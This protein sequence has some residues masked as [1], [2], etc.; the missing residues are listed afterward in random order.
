MFKRILSVALA[1]LMVMAMAAVAVSAAEVSNPAG[2]DTTD[3]ATGTS[4]KIYFDASKWNNVT[5]IYCHIWINGGDQFYGWKSAEEKCKN[6][7]GSLWEYDLSALD[8]SSYI[9][10][11]LKAGEDYCLIFHAD[12]G[13][14]GYDTTFGLECIGDRATMTGNQIENPIDSEKKGYETVWS[15]NSSKYGPHFAISSIGNFLG[16]VLCPNESSTKVIG[17][18]LINYSDSQYCDPVEVLAK[19]LPKFGVK[20]VTTVMAYIMTQDLGISNPDKMQKQL[21]E[22]Y[23]AA[24]GEEVT[25]DTNEVDKKKEEIKN[26]GGSTAGVSSDEP[27]ENAG[28]TGSG[29]TGVSGSGSNSSGTGS[30]G[31]NDT[32]LFVLAAI[33]LVAA[34]AFVATRKRTEV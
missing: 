3:A 29:S 23:K 12:T 14:Q 17:D 24:Y 2:A 32:I 11:G 8:G 22:A 30:D 21:E 9:S 28:T 33:M 5:Q 7:S 34:G 20:D 6:V 25:I 4:G 19:A 31:Q 27:S 16:K 13:L 18:W 10:G 15:K 26:N 1:I